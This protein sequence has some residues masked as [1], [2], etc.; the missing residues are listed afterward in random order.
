M[1]FDK[2]ITNEAT[3]KSVICCEKLTLDADSVLDKLVDFVLTGLADKVPEHE[4]GEVCV[5]PLVPRNQL[6]VKVEDGHQA[7][8]LQD[9]VAFL[10]LIHWRA[11]RESVYGVEELVS[12]LPVLNVA[13]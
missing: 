8:L 13:G 4:A 11:P 10:E 9:L 5:K 12:V 3:R 6:V 7:L 2:N 1:V